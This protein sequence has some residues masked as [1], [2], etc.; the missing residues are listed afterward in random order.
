MW[1]GLALCIWFGLG[2]RGRVPMRRLVGWACRIVRMG[3]RLGLR[4]RLGWRVSCGALVRSLVVLG[5]LVALR[6]G[7]R[8]RGSSVSLLL[9]GILVERRYA[10]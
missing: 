10:S 9:G 2:R 4:L 1:R 5:C 3:R 8:V 7:L 6:V